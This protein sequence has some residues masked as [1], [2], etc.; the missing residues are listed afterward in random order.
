MHRYTVFEPIDLIFGCG[1]GLYNVINCV[2][3]FENLLCCVVTSTVVVIV[4]MLVATA[5]MFYGLV[6]N[7][8]HFAYCVL[9]MHSS[10]NHRMHVPFYG[11]FISTRGVIF[12]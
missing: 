10:G 9:L 3:V 7:F 4:P 2:E 1:M 5:A 12:G 11:L 8:C 6:T